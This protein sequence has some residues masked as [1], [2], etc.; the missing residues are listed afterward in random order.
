MLPVFQNWRLPLLDERHGR[1]EPPLLFI[2]KLCPLQLG[3]DAIFQLPGNPLSQSR[4][5]WRVHKPHI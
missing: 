1:S 5:E 4:P 2:R 3:E